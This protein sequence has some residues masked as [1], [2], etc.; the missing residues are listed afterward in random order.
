MVCVHLPHNTSSD[1]SDKSTSHQPSQIRQPCLSKCTWTLA[2]AP[3]AAIRVVP[4]LVLTNLDASDLEQH[5]D[6]STARLHKLE[7]STTAKSN[8]PDDSN[9][10]IIAKTIKSDEDGS[11][12]N[13]EVT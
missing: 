6:V 12:G 10:N 8:N 5:I 7:Y 2:H 13:D 1:R 4:Y 9:N 11:R 3:V